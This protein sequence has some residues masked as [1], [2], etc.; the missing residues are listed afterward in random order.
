MLSG[1]LKEQIRQVP[2]SMLAA[3][4]SLPPADRVRFIEECL[5][6]KSVM[7][8]CDEEGTVG[9]NSRFSWDHA[10]LTQERLQAVKVR[11]FHFERKYL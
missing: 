3:L 1:T 9:A 7:T 11:T 4:G 8:K 10:G 6:E 2:S 5:T